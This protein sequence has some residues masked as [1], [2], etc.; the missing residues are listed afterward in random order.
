MYLEKK[1]D[2][3]ESAFASSG[4]KKEHLPKDYSSA[5]Q[6]PHLIYRFA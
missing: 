6:K 1:A 3:K 4:H 5:L 2:S